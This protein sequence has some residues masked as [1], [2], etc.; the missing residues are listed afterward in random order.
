MDGC[1]DDAGLLELI[2]GQLAPPA[3][4]EVDAHLDRCDSCRELVALAARG[5]DGRHAPAADELR[6]GDAV[7]RYIVLGRI[8]GGAMGVVYAAHDRELDRK[9]ALKLLRPELAG[10]AAAVVRLTSDG[11]AAAVAASTL[12]AGSDGHRDR[13][14]REAQAMARLQHPN[15]V[16]VH[17]VGTAGDRVFVAMELVAGPTLRG[18][19]HGRPWRE[20][21]R[22]LVAVGRGLAA[23]HAAGVIHRDVKPDNIIV[24]Q[25][26][27]PRIGDFG[28]ARADEETGGAPASSILA[29][30]L[31]RTG[32]VIGT[33]LYMAPEQLR[34]EPATAN[35]DQFGFAVTAWE[36]LFGARPFVGKDLA[37]LVRAIDR[38][39]LPPARGGV[40]VAVER[41]LRRGLDPDPARRHDGVDALI[42][43]IDWQPRR[44][45]VWLAPAATAAAV[46]ATL[47]VVRPAAAPIDPC[48]RAAAA[49]DDSWTP[50]VA[51]ELGDKLTAAHDR[52]S[53]ARL[54]AWA[55]RW[56]AAR[57]EVCRA[58]RVRGAESE[59]LLDVRGACLDRGRAELAALVAELRVAELTALTGVAEA[60]AALTDPGECANSSALALLAP[61]AAAQ[62]AAV[63]EVERTAAVV[64]A[65][66]G[67][68][69]R[70]DP[71]AGAALVAAATATGHAP[72]LA[73]AH[74][75]H[76][77]L[78]RRAGDA[79]AADVAARAAVVAAEIGHDDLGAARA[80]ISRVGAAGDRRDL[81]AVDEWTQLAGAAVTRAGDPPPLVARLAND[82]G[83][84]AMNRGE[85]GR[86]RH[87]LERALAI[88]R[89]L[90]GAA[91][92]LDVARTL[93]ALGHV[94]RLRGE[95]DRA[96]A[97]FDEAVAIEEG[98]LDP[99]HPE[100]AR[101][102]HNAAGALRLLGRLD[103]AEARYR[104]ALRL[105][106]AALGPDHPDVGLSHNSL[107][108]V[109]I[110]RGQY[111]VAEREL[112]EARR[113]VAAAGH[114]ELPIVLA[115]LGLV[116]NRQGR[117]RI[118][119]ALLDNAVVQYRAA[120]P[121]RHERLAR[122]LLDASDAAAGLGDVRRAR[123]LLA[124]ARAAIPEEA[125]ERFVRE[126]DERAVAL[127]PKAARAEPA[128]PEPEVE[129]KVE[130]EP[131]PELKPELKPE[132]KP[133]PKPKV[134]VG[135]YGSGQGWD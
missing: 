119:L 31:T 19:A 110:E 129:P 118:A 125:G 3:L 113:I 64:R 78:L 50:A 1:L 74:L 2:H 12:A 88:R 38:G 81:G 85:L 117:F 30:T 80:W 20:C 45:W 34:G 94:A 37:E 126:A 67:T 83:L 11:A 77:E 68:S 5:S 49:L 92:D 70:V 9:V 123:A 114:G 13:V 101:D 103:E 108:L 10:P 109:A 53:V 60:V 8:G 104:L 46:A 54:D 23:A 73:A 115:N 107:G 66:L 44:R 27:R 17:D 7:D 29:T 122:A 56:R 89:T 98:V 57:L 84:L 75:V 72:T 120:L 33:P 106:T 71:A 24:D 43:A 39:P 131:K 116:A 4:V 91:P 65:R 59:R 86:A 16:T 95:F 62:R 90:A 87:E 22:C 121:P 51:T 55:G 133:E 25:H 52:T 18:W 15:V 102:H 28:L 76:A 135:T 58:G 132:P 99:S 35:S 124:A 41:A 6:P 40:P 63:A 105:R 97:W 82:L 42:G 61:V 79:V 134:P 128:T 69:T 14:L 32:A 36:M 112:G 48:R 130:P 127:A 26:D 47:L 96:L 21:L 100:V 93:S 111:E